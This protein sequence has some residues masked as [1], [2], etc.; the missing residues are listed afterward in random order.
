M[1]AVTLDQIQ[2]LIDQLTPLEQIRLLEYLTPRIEHVIAAKQPSPRKPASA[3][4]WRTFFHLGDALAASD[5]PDAPTLTQSVL[6]MR[7]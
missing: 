7:R 4:A 2:R 1:S 3:E 6:T 5:R